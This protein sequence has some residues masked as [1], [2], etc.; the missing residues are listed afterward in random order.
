MP[1][2]VYRIRGHIIL[3]CPLTTV[4]INLD[5][6]GKELSIDVCHYKVTIFFS[7]LEK[8]L[9]GYENVL[10][11]LKH[12]LIDFAFIYW[13]CLQQLLL[14]FLMVIFYLYFFLLFKISLMLSTFIT[15][16]YT[17][18]KICSFSPHSFISFS[19]NLLYSLDWIPILPL[20]VM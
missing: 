19:I 18:R 3:I 4:D 15:W 8:T 16:N 14:W 20:F 5:S 1:F 7:I 12:L 9:C 11:L 6:L 10:F 17:I 13:F 2:S